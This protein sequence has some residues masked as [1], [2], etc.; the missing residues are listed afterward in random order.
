MQ[1]ILFTDIE[2]STKVTHT[3][4]D[5]AAHKL[6]R[7][8]DT[9]VR[10]ALAG[11]DGKEVK[12]TG[13]GIMAVFQSA[14]AALDSAI[15][16]QRVLAAFNKK[17]AKRLRVSIG[18]NAGEPIVENDDL[19]GS[20]VQVAARL[21]ERAAGGEILV[22][23]VI[24]LLLMGK[25]YEF[26]DMGHLELKGIQYPVQVHSVDALSLHGTIPFREIQKASA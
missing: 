17:S 24:R 2:A 26:I 22:S 14:S 21:C 7:T 6:V 4:G 15:L 10:K 23:E 25:R 12:H 16:T 9:I 11:T 20:A 18:I 5:E 1:V 3:I 8:H 13:D 19:F